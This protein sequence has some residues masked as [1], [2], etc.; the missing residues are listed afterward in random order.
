MAK[1]DTRTRLGATQSLLQSDLAS[2]SVHCRKHGYTPLMYACIATDLTQ[3]EKEV[4][5]IKVSMEYV[6]ACFR[7]RTQKSGHAAVGIHIISM[8]RL[9][10]Q[11]QDVAAAPSDTTSSTPRP[12]RCTLV[13]KALTEHDLGTS[14]TKSCCDLLLACNSFQVMEHVAQEEAHSFA[15]RLRDRRHQR[16]SRDGLPVSLGFRNF[17]TF[18]GWEFVVALLKSE[19][20]HTY[21][22]IKPVPPFNAL[23]MA[24]CITDFP[25]PFLMLCMRAYPTQICERPIR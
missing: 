15:G 14:F 9:K 4:P 13:V 12:P 18:W 25:L 23:H 2:A 1:E 11:P 3:L 24:S 10:N 19:H 6:P 16:A 22:S 7:V 21:Q 5:V 8:S 17:H 20:Q